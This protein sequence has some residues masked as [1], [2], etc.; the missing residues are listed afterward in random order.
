[1][2]NKNSEIL[3]HLLDEDFGLNTKDGSRW[4]KGESHDSMVLDK[5]R[6]LIFWNSQGL[7]LDPLGYLTKIRKLDFNNAKDYLKKFDYEGTFVYTIRSGDEDIV[8][9]PKLV[10]V[11]WEDG[12][13]PERREFLYNRG[14]ENQTIDRFQI[15]WYNGWTMIPIIIDGVFRNFYMRNEKPV[16]RTRSYYK[17]GALMFNSDI[18]KLVSTVY[19]VEGPVDALILNQNGIPAI[20]TTNSLS[21]FSPE[22]YSKFLGVKE[23]IIFGDY[24]KAGIKEARRV[25]KTLGETRC[26]LFIYDK[27]DQKGYDPVDFFR[28]GHTK[29]ELMELVEKEGKFIYEV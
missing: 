20:S 17:T 7:V 16:K 29:D 25:C 23:I 24:D 18:L 14:I 3:A 5:D 28:D 12:R 26:K 21:G 19:I 9:Y 8:V 13:K 22:W 4:G 6:G 1:M 2:S 10:D 27:V 11:F 15:G